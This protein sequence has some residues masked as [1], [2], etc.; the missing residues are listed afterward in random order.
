MSTNT[1]GAD[2]SSLASDKAWSTI[3]IGVAGFAGAL[4]PRCVGNRGA[5]VLSGATLFSA[6]VL[7]S[8]GL[9]HL[10]PDAIDGALKVAPDMEFPL[11]ESSRN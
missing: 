9:V 2:T 3:A 8:A 1:T 4:L 10:L 5:R 6:G 11:M 7:L